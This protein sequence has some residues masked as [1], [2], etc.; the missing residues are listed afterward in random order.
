MTLLTKVNKKHI[1]NLAFINVVSKVVKR[2]VFINIAAVSKKLGKGEHSS[3][4]CPCV[5]DE[6]KRFCDIDSVR[7]LRTL[8]SLSH[9]PS[10]P[11]YS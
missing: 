1:Y 8:P 4:L 10:R 7:H 11:R 6:Y 5:G 3:L 9:P 2:K